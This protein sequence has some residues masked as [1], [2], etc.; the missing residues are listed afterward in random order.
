MCGI[1]GFLIKNNAINKEQSIEL[2]NDMTASITHRGPDEKAL[3][4]DET[5]A[6]GMQR[7]AI[8]DLSENIYPVFSQDKSNILIFNGEIYNYKE[9]RTELSQKY[10]FITD[11]DSEV[12]I[13]GY[14]EWGKEIFSKLRGMFAIALWD[15]RESKL[16]LV[17]DRLG[18]KP[19][20]YVENEKGLFFASEAKALH[21]IINGKLSKE[22]LKLLLGFM[23]LPNSEDTVIEGVKK[24]P[25]A[26]ILEVTPKSTKPTITKYWSPMVDQKVQGLN[27]DEA[28]SQLE[29][30]LVETVKMHLMSDVALGLLLSGGVDSSLLAGIITKNNLSKSLNTY[31][32]KFSH[33]NNESELAKKT[34][35]YLGT[36]HHELF[37]DTTRVGEQIEDLIDVFDDL[38]TFDG[39]IITTKLLCNQIRKDG[40]KVLLLGEGADE[41]FGG[42]SWFGLSQSP[43]NLFPKY[44][45]TWLYYYATSR[46]I[47]VNPLRY[48]NY[49]NKKFTNVTDIFAQISNFEL[50][51]QL[52]NH[53]LMKVDKGSMSESIEARVPYLDHK[54]VEFV[55]SLKAE[56]KL[57]GTS[58]NFAKSNE[59]YILREIAKKYLPYDVSTRKKRGFMLPMKDIIDSSLPKIKSYLLARDSISLSL[60][61]RKFIE[62]LFINTGY[63]LLD[64]E[65]EYFLWRL[66][67]LE[68]WARKFEY[69]L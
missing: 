51:T 55:Y 38:T 5:C 60:F 31:T 4:H 16:V 22:N 52:P 18:I 43:A 17:R 3:F 62:S 27:F 15:K 32:A 45:R 29:K 24:L 59:K 58:I 34:A 65:K 20:Y 11:S 26:C 61:S 14:S 19:I 12:I 9:L 67:I 50:T 8:V 33:K 66:S 40:T 39:G 30:L 28:Y 1:A 2:L 41:L 37:I 68:V 48:V 7:L 47:G 10:K 21:K 35:D 57:N 64:M 63:S 69:K 13:H 49:L 25:S 42:Y 23:Y 54:L 36:V 46:N 44:F 56:F 6:L 53:L